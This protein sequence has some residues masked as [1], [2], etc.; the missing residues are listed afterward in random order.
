M[1]G[2][3]EIDFKDRAVFTALRFAEHFAGRNE[4]KR[5]SLKSWIRSAQQRNHDAILHKL[6]QVKKQGEFLQ[7]EQRSDITPSEFINNYLN[8]ARPLVLRGAARDWECCKTWTPQFFADKCG[9]DRVI[10]IN[11]HI[12]T[13]ESVEDEISLREIIANLGTPKAKYARFV[14]ILNNHPELFKDFDVQW[15]ADRIDKNGKVRLW[16]EGG[17]GKA[18]R[19][20]LFIGSKNNKTEVHCALTNNFFINVYGRKR[21][22]IF[23]PSFNPLVYSPINWG[24]GVFGSEVSPTDPDFKKHPLW[25]YVDIYEVVLEPGDI[26]FNPP[27]WWHHVTNFSDSIAIGIRWYD[28]KTAMK[29]SSTQNLLSLLS[30]NPT[31][32][33]AVKN[34]IEY[35]KTH[36]TKK[37]KDLR[38]KEEMLKYGKYVNEL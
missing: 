15:L 14:P 8:Q 32:Y 26:L 33:S 11:D 17:K 6:S 23:A 19:S 12:A 24:P 38:S 22:F 10:L 5:S 35:G 28:F 27:F 37:R 18:L 3:Y 4:K 36:G 20:H 16:N 31:M 1:L 2:A 7:I 30:T 13:D 9:D 29:S 25:K 21:W 34:A